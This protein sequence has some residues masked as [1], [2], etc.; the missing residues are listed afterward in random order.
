MRTAQNDR[1]DGEGAR[2]QSPLRTIE[3]SSDPVAWRARVPNGERQLQA[4]DRIAVARSKWC[5][6]FE[7]LPHRRFDIRR[8]DGAGGASATAFERRT[9]RGA[10][11]SNGQ[12]GEN[13]IHCASVSYDSSRG[14]ARGRIDSRARVPR[15]VRA[16]IHCELAPACRSSL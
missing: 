14:A 2:E 1:F 11:R 13:R 3:R 15:K 12:R 7:V 8:R 6:R 10:A 16:A 5:G 9:I 4:V